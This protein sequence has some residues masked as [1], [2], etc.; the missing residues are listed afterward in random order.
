MSTVFIK[1]WDDFNL[2]S[3]VASEGFENSVCVAWLKK[4]VHHCCK[5]LCHGGVIILAQLCLLMYLLAINWA[6][7]LANSRHVLT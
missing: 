1:L 4:F 2:H 7:H 6:G 3:C 5:Y